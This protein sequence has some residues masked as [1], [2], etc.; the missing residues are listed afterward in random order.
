MKKNFLLT[1]LVLLLAYVANAQ[2]P[3]VVLIFA[4]DLTFESLGAFNNDEIHTPNLDRLQDMGVTFSHAFNQGS[5]CP[6]VC[7]ASRTMLNTGKFVW[8]AATYSSN[9]MNKNDKNR[10]ANEP[11]YTVE[12]ATPKGYWSEYMKAAGYDTYMAGK[13]HVP[14][15]ASSLFD[16]TGT[17]RG[18]MPN[19]TQARY[20]RS[21]V[22]GEPDTWSPYDK[23]K[24]GFWK[25]GKHWSE[26]LCDEAIGFVE[27][28]A[29]KE[30]PFFMYLGFNA[31]HDPRQA[32]KEYVDMYPLDKISVPESFMPEYPY[33]SESCGGMKLRDEKLAPFPRTPYSVKVNRQEYYALITHMDAQIGR[34]L[35]AIEASGKADNTYIMFTADHG[36]ALGDHGFIGKQNMYDRSMRVPFLLVGPEVPKGEVVDEMIY[37]QDAMS[38]ALDIAGSPAIEDVDFQ[39]LLPL[40]NGK[41]KTEYDAI[42]GTYVGNQR[43]IRTERYKMII[44]PT[45]NVVRLYDLK[46][47]PEEM[48]DLASVKK[49]KKTLQTLFS[50]FKVLQEEVNDP[51]DVEVYFENFMATLE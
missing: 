21:M 3:N 15:K 9:S 10:P 28:A 20:D 22:E 34:I 6:G 14:A 12:K 16:V 18:G 26:V 25:G 36:L 27:T 7:V 43:M 45:A 41:N 17:V 42:Y 5:W 46:K 49:Y 35:D 29:Q 8:S 2:Q 4:D 11:D 31:A 13:W 38:T 39:S 1:S 24:N 48:H 19:Q 40:C 33:F 30:A 50:Q 23:S 51:L 47:D 37:L 44:Y 32:P